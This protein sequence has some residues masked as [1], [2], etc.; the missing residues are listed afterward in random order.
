MFA[1]LPAVT[2]SVQPGI[3]PRAD[4][5]GRFGG[6]LAWVEGRSACGVLARGVFLRAAGGYRRPRGREKLFDHLGETILMANL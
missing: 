6:L 2:G 4:A 1:S 3:W 5:V